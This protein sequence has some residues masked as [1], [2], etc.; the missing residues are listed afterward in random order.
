MAT[1]SSFKSRLRKRLAK[2]PLRYAARPVF[3]ALV[4]AQLV[5]IR[6]WDAAQPPTECDVRRVTAIVKTF[7]RPRLL[8]RLVESLRRHFAELT[9][10]V[11]DDS[12]QPTH[13]AGVRTIELPFDSGVSAGRQA[14]LE[15]VR[16]DLTWV[17]DDD[18]S[19]TAGR[20][21]PGAGRARAVSELDL[22]GGP[23]IDLPLLSRRAP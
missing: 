8:R 22:V 7:E 12:R 15:A 18:S 6:G 4:A 23:V 19:F 11:V 9:V 5:A 20:G 21:W 13:L 2:A 3:D 14:A 17:L 10:I 16:T 1:P